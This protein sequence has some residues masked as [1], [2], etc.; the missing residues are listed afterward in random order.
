MIFV[1]AGAWFAVAVGTLRFLLDTVGEDRVVFGSDYCGGLG[2]LEKALPVIEDQP[3]AARIKTL[4][5][6][7]S[8]TLRRL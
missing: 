3:D 7:T 1:D 6:R 4:T 5:E 2:A 8:R